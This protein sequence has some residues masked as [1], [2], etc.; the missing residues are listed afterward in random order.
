MSAADKLELME[1]TLAELTQNESFQQLSESS[2][3]ETMKT[4]VLNALDTMKGAHEEVGQLQERVRVS[5][6]RAQVAR[7]INKRQEELLSLQ[8]QTIEGLKAKLSETGQGSPGLIDARDE[9][10]KLKL[11]EDVSALE[12]ELAESAKAAFKLKLES[13]KSYRRLSADFEEYRANI[14]AEKQ[15]KAEDLPTEPIVDL[16]QK[17]LV[18]NLENECAKISKEFEVLLFII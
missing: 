10:V 2:D 9:A 18:Q 12:R 4:S 17:A 15:K 3:I 5:D 8:Q 7:D 6:E 14:E 1:Q 11:E 13:E 16:V